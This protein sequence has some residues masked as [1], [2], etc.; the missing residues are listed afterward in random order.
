[1]R[2]ILTQPDIW[3]H[4]GDDFAGRPEDFQ[5]PDDPRI[6][7]LLATSGSSVLGLFTF[8]PQSRVTWEAHV[9]MLPEAFGK[10]AHQAAQAIVSWIWANTEC[11]RIV[12]AVPQ[13]NRRAVLY[14][15]RSLGLRKFGVDE[16]SFLKGGVMRDRIL[17]GISRPEGV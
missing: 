7:Y 14:G 11:R 16:K 4:I 1:M 15:I 13:S 17:L 2:Y 9:A 5:P 8:L 6:R 3:P 12:A 10:P